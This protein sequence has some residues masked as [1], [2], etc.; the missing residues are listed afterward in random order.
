MNSMIPMR[1]IMILALLA[2]GPFVTG[3]EVR[4]GATH[5]DVRVTLKKVSRE[6]LKAL[7]FDWLVDAKEPQAERGFADL[8]QVR[9]SSVP[10]VDPVE[11]RNLF[12]KLQRN[13][14]E[15]FLRSQDGRSPN[16]SKKPNKP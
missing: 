3:Q 15:R 1:A 2:T 16:M 13:G 8:R 10:G 6:E 12:D 9:F 5:V 7:G 4:D 14:F 11:Y